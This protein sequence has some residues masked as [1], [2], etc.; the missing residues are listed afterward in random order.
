LKRLLKLFFIALSLKDL[1][2]LWFFRRK[3]LLQKLLFKWLQYVHLLVVDAYSRMEL[4]TATRLNHD[5]GDG[6]V[7]DIVAVDVYSGVE[8]CTL[9]FLGEASK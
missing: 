8:L 2:F 1:G 4:C 9:I 3:S 7:V 6:R 5:Y